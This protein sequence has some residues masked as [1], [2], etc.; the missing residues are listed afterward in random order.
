MGDHKIGGDTVEFAIL[1][2]GSTLISMTKGDFL[3]L[4]TAYST[5]QGPEF[6]GFGMPDAQNV[7]S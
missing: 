4:V 2:T 6:I 7:Y 5:H 3:R 1:D